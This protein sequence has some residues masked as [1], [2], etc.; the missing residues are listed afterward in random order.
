MNTVWEIEDINKLKKRSKLIK[1]DMK[2]NNLEE[3]EFRK[4]EILQE[5]KEQIKSQIMSYFIKNPSLD[6]FEY[7]NILEEKEIRI[8]SAN[9]IEYRLWE[10]LPFVYKWDIRLVAESNKFNQEL[11]IDKLTNNMW[12]LICEWYDIKDFEYDD[13]SKIK[14]LSTT[15]FIYRENWK[16]FVKIFDANNTRLLSNF[17]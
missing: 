4:R 17:E 13:I 3:D 5:N 8:L 12:L 11:V 14:F 7:I 9:R 10:Q 1:N 2:N 6:I 15:A 16:T